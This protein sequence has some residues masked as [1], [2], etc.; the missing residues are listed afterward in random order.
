MMYNT[1][2]IAN[3][4]T[5]TIGGYANLK[6]FYRSVFISDTH[7]GSRW[8]QAQ[9]LVSFLKNARCEHLYLVGDLLESKKA[10]KTSSWSSSQIEVFNQIHLK[11]LEGR[12]VY[13][14]GN[15]DY[16]MRDF[17]GRQFG[18]LEVQPHAVH[19][20]A[21]GKR[22]LVLH[23]DQ[24]DKAVS[25]SPWVTRLGDLAYNGALWLNLWVNKLRH[26]LGMSYW[27]ISQFLKHEVKIFI[28]MLSAFEKLLQREAKRHRCDG[29]ICGH[30]HRPAINHMGD[31]LYVNCGD[32]VES[33]SAVVE[34]EDGSFEILYRRDVKK[35]AFEAKAPFKVTYPAFSEPIP[36]GLVSMLAK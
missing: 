7:L 21:D 5:C 2:R 16:C 35:P 24:F 13:V 30:I 3:A 23:G 8:C 12:V 1:L 29:V 17:I 9:K 14:P 4:H 10:M 36:L 15:H 31:V 25:L 33:C 11:S 22:M 32:W 6:T 34:H 26:W 19:R 28:Q 18:N 20:T 27:P